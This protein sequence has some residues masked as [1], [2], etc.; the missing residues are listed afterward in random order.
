M[1]HFLFSIAMRKV[2]WLRMLLIESKFL[3]PPSALFWLI[4]DSLITLDSMFDFDDMCSNKRFS[5]SSSPL[6]LQSLQIDGYIGERRNWVEWWRFYFLT[7]WTRKNFANFFLWRRQNENSVV[8]IKKKTEKS[9]INGSANEWMTCFIFTNPH[10]RSQNI[11]F[12]F[13]WFIVIFARTKLL[14]PLVGGIQ[15]F[16]HVIF[17]D[18]QVHFKNPFWTFHHQTCANQF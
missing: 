3:F 11:H 5:S 13:R 17:N 10:A 7:Q 4:D 16:R 15:K 8:K 14:F 2:N 6:C 12:W 1:S 9:V 18:I